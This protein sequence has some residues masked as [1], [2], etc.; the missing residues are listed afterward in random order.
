MPGAHSPELRHWPGSG[1]RGAAPAPHPA[2]W[3]DLGR[4]RPQP[5]RVCLSV[6][7]APFPTPVRS[8]IKLGQ[9]VTVG[10]IP[11]LGA[12][13][14]LFL[15]LKEKALSSLTL[16][17]FPTRDW[18]KGPHPLQLLGVP[19]AS[20]DLTQPPHRADP[21][22]HPHLG[23]PSSGVGPQLTH[24]SVPCGQNPGVPTTSPSS[25]RNSG[26]RLT[27]VLPADETGSNSGIA[28][29]GVGGRGCARCPEPSLVQATSPCGPGTSRKSPHHIS[30]GVADGLVTNSERHCLLHPSDLVA[31]KAI[32]AEDSPSRRLE[33]PRESLRQG[34]VTGLAQGHGHT[35]RSGAVWSLQCRYRMRC[36][37]AAGDRKVPVLALASLGST[38]ARLRRGAH[39]TRPLIA[40]G[41][42]LKPHSYLHPSIHSL[43]LHSFIL[44]YVHSFTH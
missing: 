25:S 30:A 39:P 24:T 13:G 5:C 28:R 11:S 18:G 29:R 44:I 43:I 2:T 12:C 19:P 23:R 15:L 34:E 36:T 32:V 14:L 7:Q 6:T 26:K 8:G 27:C 10:I 40:P 4:P 33:A 1:D 16:T 38:G 35:G 42:F 17:P 3:G 37:Q 22:G 31:G 9:Q 20:W 41:G 21:A